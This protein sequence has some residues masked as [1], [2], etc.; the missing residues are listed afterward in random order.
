MEQ[1][2]CVIYEITGAGLPAH[3]AAQELDLMNN[4]SY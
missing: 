3:E 1:N 2:L 4:S